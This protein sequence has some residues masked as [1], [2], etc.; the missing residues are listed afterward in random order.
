M[1]FRCAV[2][3]QTS[4]RRREREFNLFGNIY[5][6]ASKWTHIQVVWRHL[7]C[8]TLWN[9]IFVLSLVIFSFFSFPAFCSR[10]NLEFLHVP[11]FLRLRKLAQSGQEMMELE[12][13]SFQN[14]KI[15]S[16]VCVCGIWSSIGKLCWELAAPVLKLCWLDALLWINWMGS[17]QTSRIVHTS[18]QSPQT[19]RRGNVMETSAHF[20]VNSCVPNAHIS[21]QKRL[22]PFLSP[23]LIISLRESWP[24]CKL[25]FTF[26]FWWKL[27]FLSRG[28]HF[29]N[30]K[31]Q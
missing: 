5:L 29:M 20:I 2:S 18:H 25:L 16:S 24:R 8:D 10:F 12:K 28:R 22:C 30:E 17:I 3:H 27:F 4:W 9:I 23:S 13:N 15:F 19:I 7:S 21:W 31:K 14:G 26:F 1:Q 6:L 11:L